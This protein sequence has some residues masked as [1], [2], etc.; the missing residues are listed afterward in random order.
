MAV[1]VPVWRLT[2][3]YHQAAGG[4]GLIGGLA[5]SPEV[6]ERTRPVS[7]SHNPFLD[8]SEEEGE[9]EEGEG[10]GRRGSTLLGHQ[11]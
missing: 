4:P 10:G 5:D 8:D 9:E 6:S 1:P 2:S 11:R 3:H 7:P